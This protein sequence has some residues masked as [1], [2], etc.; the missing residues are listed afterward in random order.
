[1][2]AP[3]VAVPDVSI[4]LVTR[5]GAGSLP[6]V[7][8]AVERQ[9]GTAAVEVIV[10]DSGSTDDTR[11]LVEPRVDLFVSI[12]PSTFNHGLTRN[13]GISRARGT[14]VVL[15]VQDAVPVGT[16]W[17]AALTA[18]FKS[19]PALAGTFA[20]QIVRPDASSL[21]HAYARRWFA[22][23][24][25]GR[26]AALADGQSLSHLPPFERVDLCTFD[27]V[28]SCIRRSVWET[29]PFRETPIAEDIEWA[30]TVLTAGFALAYVPEAVVTHSH[31][32]PASYEFARTML[33]HRRLVELFEFR[34]VPT[35]GALARSVG[36]TLRFHAGCLRG[37]LRRKRSAALVWRALTL[38]L[39]W[40]AG[41]YLGGRAASKGWK[42]LRFRD[43]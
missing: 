19:D 36:S 6:A 32:R 3:H 31:E 29:H 18:P 7:L 24:L 17:L 11:R 5:N 16:G 21:T 35:L 12:P 34:T 2:A 25:E 37:D 27:N 42:A 33:L 39:A 22:T 38:A 23:G 8:D 43:V 13:H 9:Q 10:V 1:M 14:L 4:V 20:R 26:R 30:A 41:Q 28:C 40:P 15:L